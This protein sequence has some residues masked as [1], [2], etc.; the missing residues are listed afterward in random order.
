MWEWPREL[1]T[2]G[3]MLASSHSAPSV[4]GTMLAAWQTG[5]TAHTYKTHRNKILCLCPVFKDKFFFQQH[6]FQTYANH[7]ICYSD[8]KKHSVPKMEE[9]PALLF[10]ILKDSI[11]LCIM[12]SCRDF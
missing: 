10:I 8:E 1:R 11:M 9:K 12:A 6:G 5:H 4:P 3:T 2:R 7:F